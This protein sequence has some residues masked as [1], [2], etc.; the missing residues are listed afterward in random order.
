MA[1]TITLAGSLLASVLCAAAMPVSAQ[2]GAAGIAGTWIADSFPD[3][4]LTLSGDEPPLTEEGAELYRANLA[5]RDSEQPQF[6][7]TRWCAGPG[8]PRIMFMPSPFEII[9]NRDLIG[10]VYGWYRWHRVVDMSGEEVEPLLPQTMG[11]PVGHWE[12]DVL[13]IDTNGLTSD[14]ILDASG[15]PHSDDMELNERIEA[16][17][18]G[19]LRIRFRI[20][21]PEIFSESWE[22]E[23]TYH[24]PGDLS[25]TDDVCPDRIAEGKPA[26]PLPE[27]VQR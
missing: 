14:T 9:P 4:L 10:F 5:D 13:V 22:T 26:I 16:L 12:G 7:R 27:E 24:R 23:M 3:R 8:V 21:D 6:D 20:T 2:D 19:R 15:L 18:D 1:R 17:P 11:Y 25:V